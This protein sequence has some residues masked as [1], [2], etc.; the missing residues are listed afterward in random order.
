MN[1]IKEEMNRRM[2]LFKGQVSKELDM[3]NK[4]EGKLKKRMLFIESRETEQGTIYTNI[5]RLR[6]LKKLDGDIF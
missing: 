4:L 3:T 6:K 5:D 2:N 1:D